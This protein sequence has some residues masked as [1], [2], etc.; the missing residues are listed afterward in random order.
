M[1]FPA[2]DGPWEK[3][4]LQL[5]ASAAVLR[6]SMCRG[7]MKPALPRLIQ[8]NLLMTLTIPPFP[9]VPCGRVKLS[10]AIRTLSN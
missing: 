6:A 3:Q 5:L 8:E 9:Q 10:F 1:I 2:C 7:E 4:A